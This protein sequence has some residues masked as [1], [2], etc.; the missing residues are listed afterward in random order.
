M[1]AVIQASIDFNRQPLL[2]SEFSYQGPCMV[3]YD[4]D[5]DG[6][7]DVVIGGAPGQATS[8]YLQQRNGAFVRKIIP[9]FEQDKG[10]ADARYKHL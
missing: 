10:Y 4:L 3:K 9:A 6:L 7:D 8:L 2:I 1:K 5:K